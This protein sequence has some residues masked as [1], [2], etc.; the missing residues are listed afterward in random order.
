MDVSTRTATYHQDQDYRM[1]ANRPAEEV[2]MS[3]PHNLNL[4]HKYLQLL[5]TKQLQLQPRIGRHRVVLR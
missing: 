2:E 5:T 3:A 1:E 4:I